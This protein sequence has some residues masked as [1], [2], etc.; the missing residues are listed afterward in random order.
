MSRVL[1]ACIMGLIMYS[2]KFTRP[3]VAYDLSMVNKYQGNPSLSHCTVVKNILKYLKKTKYMILVFCGKDELKMS[4]Y[5]DADFQI[6][7]D[8]SYS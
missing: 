8:N 3:D 6:D 1:Y 5:S 7:R 4:G 2:I